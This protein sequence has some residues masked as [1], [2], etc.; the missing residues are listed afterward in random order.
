M[1]NMLKDESGCNVVIGQNG[2]VY[3]HCDNAENIYKVQEAIK[4]IESNT[5]SSGLTEK[6]KK[7]L[8]GGK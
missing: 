2:Y 7:M 6:V 8:G 4:L 3:V 1:I 5:T